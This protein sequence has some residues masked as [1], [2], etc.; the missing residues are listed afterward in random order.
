MKQLLQLDDIQGVLARG[1]GSLPHACFLLLKVETSSAQVALKKLLPFVQTSKEKPVNFAINMAFSFEGLSKLKIGKQT[2]S[3]F[4]RAFRQGM[5]T[6][7]RA[8]I[9]GDVEDNSA[10]NWR[11]GAT[12]QNS[13]QA[14]LML[15]ANSKENLSKLLAVTACAPDEKHIKEV[16]DAIALLG[17]NIFDKIMSTPLIDKKEHFGF[18]DGISQPKI[19]GIANTQRDSHKGGNILAA[20]EFIFGYKDEYDLIPDTS[21]VHMIDDPH[22][23]LYVHADSNY[24]DFGRNGSYMVF[25]QLKQDVYAFWDFLRNKFPNKAERV[26]IASKMLGRWPNGCPIKA[27]ETKEPKMNGDIPPLDFS[28]DP[29]G[30]GCPIASHVRRCNPR[31]STFLRENI[32]IT[33]SNTHRILRRGRNYGSPLTDSMQPEDFLKHGQDD[34]ERGLCFICF[35]TNIERQFEFVQ[36][37]WIINKKFGALRNDPDPIIGV[38]DKKGKAQFTF[39]AEPVRKVVHDIPQFVTTRGGGYFFMPGIRALNYLLQ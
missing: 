7:H 39:P 25:R 38:P 14:V 22:N 13:P 16:A 8:R 2:L 3:E 12:G 33:S 37:S 4:P 1:Y 32:D 31:K 35:N 19:A 20:G 17:N 11:W 5:N 28:K 6:P 10:E 23:Y 21:R 36:Q 9:L 24:R 15:Y 26:L 18:R 34:K 29:H 30:L 27:G